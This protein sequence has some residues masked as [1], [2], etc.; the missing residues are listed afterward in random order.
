M[1]QEISTVF[2]HNYEEYP[3][4]VSDSDDMSRFENAIDVL[5]AREKETPKDGKSSDRIRYQAD[6]IKEFF[7][8]CLYPGAGNAICTEKSNI[9]LC[10]SAYIAFIEMI[11]QQKD[12]LMASCNKLRQFSLQ[13]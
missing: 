5:R 13:K 11:N 7:D 8:N 12:F 2:R 6:M 4:D 3:F 1:S 10:Y 9:G